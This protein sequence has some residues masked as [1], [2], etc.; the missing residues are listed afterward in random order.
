MSKLQLIF[1]LFLLSCLYFSCKADDTRPVSKYKVDESIKEEVEN[2]IYRMNDVPVGKLEIRMYEDDV[3]AFDNFGENEK[4]ELLFMTYYQNDTISIIGFAGFA[5]ALGF[6]LDL[7]S[8]NYELTYL[9]KSDMEVYNYNEEDT[10]KSFKLSV[11]CSYTSCILTAKPT[12]KKEDT[13]SG[14][15]E[16]K[17]DDFWYFGN[18]KKIKRRVELKAYFLAE[19]IDLGF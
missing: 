9:A 13:V 2:N 17:S 15:V 7:Y 19:E 16:L 11:P 12:F 1:S 3:L 14:V 8:D 6:Y 18:D 4:G 10:E 5:I